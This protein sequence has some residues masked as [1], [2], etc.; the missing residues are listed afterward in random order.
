[1]PYPGADLEK[2]FPQEERVVGNANTV[3]FRKLVLQIEPQKFRF[4]MARC[5]VLVCQHLDQ[6]LSLYH[7][8]NFLGHYNAQGELLSAQRRRRKSPAA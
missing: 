4:S 3:R 7:G 2:I 8:P 6:T 1:M 5:R